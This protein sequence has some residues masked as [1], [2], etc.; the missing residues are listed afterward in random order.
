MAAGTCPQTSALRTGRL[1]LMA[2]VWAV[3]ILSHEEVYTPWRQTVVSGE[4]K[5]PQGLPDRAQFPIVG[6]VNSVPPC[7]G[8]AT[9]TAWGAT[10]PRPA[11]CSLGIRESSSPSFRAAAPSLGT[12]PSP[13]HLSVRLPL[14]PVPW[15]LHAWMPVRR[16][17]Y[18]EALTL[19]L[20]LR[21]SRA[22]FL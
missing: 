9:A 5:R 8:L 7:E 12:H 21:P 13:G 19:P 1:S 17:G 10:L 2:G 22:V 14:G 11:C 16:R 15:T 18:L 3:C 4:S 20:S 6:L